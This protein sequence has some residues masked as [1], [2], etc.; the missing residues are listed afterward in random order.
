MRTR[1]G[2]LLA[3]IMILLAALAP[4][5][6]AVWAGGAPETAGGSLVVHF[7][8]VDQG[9]A[10]LIQGPGVAILIDAGRHDR[11]DVVPY[12][13]QQGVTD[14]DLV[15]IT[16]PHADHLGQ[17]PR[18]MQAF[19]VREVWMSG[20]VH[21]TRSFER[22]LDAVLESQ[23][24]YHEP[25][26][27][28]TLE[29]GVVQLQ[30]LN[31][32]MLTDDVHD[33]SIAVRIVHG[34]VA[35]LFTGDAE[36]HTEE[37]ILRRGLPVR[38]SVLQLGHHGSRTSSSPAFVEAVSPRV[39]VY[40]AGKG[41][42]YGHPHPEVIQR[43]KAAGIAVYGTDVH[44]TIRIISDGRSFQVWPSRAPEAEPITSGATTAG[45]GRA[46]EGE[47]S[48]VEVHPPAAREAG[49]LQGCRPGQ[50]DLNTASEEELLRIVHIGSARAKAIIAMRPLQNLSQLL[51]ISGIGPQRFEDILDQ[52]L[53]CVGL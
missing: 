38:A 1:P 4:T 46:A 53:A 13:K 27:G 6:V 47:L 29:L 21:P 31:P 8:D 10:T 23:A 18:V 45:S 32:E 28:E 7:I 2:W 50:V 14:L 17:L 5:G 9:D 52:G 16:H 25:R 11:D 48:P 24:G 20:F 49:L 42:S 37:A 22:A 36:A 40:S 26:A 41:N 39:A 35:F 30:V 43:L 3:L 19:R 44:G 51:E 33:G 15:I 34:E 12:L